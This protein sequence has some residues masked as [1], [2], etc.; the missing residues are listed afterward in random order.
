M[1][2]LVELLH[3]TNNKPP[4]DLATRIDRTSDTIN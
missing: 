2:T 4:D 1:E 3:E